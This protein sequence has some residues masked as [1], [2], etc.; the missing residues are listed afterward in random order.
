ML[1]LDAVYRHIQ[2]VLT[3]QYSAG[4]ATHLWLTQTQV[5]AQWKIQQKKRMGME[6]VR[7]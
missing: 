2:S 6:K 1:P 3:E 4:I 5:E 7:S